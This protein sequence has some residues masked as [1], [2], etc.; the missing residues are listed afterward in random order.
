LKNF[1]DLENGISKKQ[2]DEMLDDTP[3]TTNRGSVNFNE[4]AEQK[5]LEKT[6]GEN[7]EGLLPVRVGSGIDTIYIGWY[8]DVKNDVLETLSTKKELAREK[9]QAVM[10]KLAGQAFRI[11]SA[12]I[13]RFPYILDNSNVTIY[14]SHS[15]TNAYPTIR[16]RFKS[17]Y[18]W[19]QGVE[20]A[21]KAMREF[22][23]QLGNVKAEKVSRVDLCADFAGVSI[24]WADFKKFVSK[25]TD[26][27]IYVTSGD[28][29]MG[30]KF[31]RG[32]VVGRV[33]NKTTEIKRT[34]KQWFYDVWGI[35]SNE[36]VWRVEYQL[37]RDFLK[38]YGI[39]EFESLQEV[40]ADIW[41]YLANDWL[42]MRELDNKNVSRRSLTSFWQAV[43]SVIDFFGN[44]TGVV[45]E[46]ARKVKVD[47]LLSIIIG[48]AVTIA[49][50]FHNQEHSNFDVDI[51][52]SDFYRVMKWIWDEVAKADVL[53]RIRERAVVMP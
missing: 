2:V 39:E 15:Q 29:I 17:L 20:D 23:N 49:A 51:A 50:V 37:R 38:E 27:N 31:G 28:N 1:S 3:S 25:A 41:K 6:Y 14:I 21:V 52:Q 32:R 19:A 5:H 30:M 11:Q 35:D 42:A 40:V 34:K 45:R 9:N 36:E 43:V 44:I 48:L 53:E 18:L 46:T 8:V 7:C 12:G 26:R 16:V 13:I 24:D 10:V 22:V 4:D 47:H 33:Y